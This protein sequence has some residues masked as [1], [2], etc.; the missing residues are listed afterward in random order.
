MKISL[1]SVLLCILISCNTSVKNEPSLF[2]AQDFETKIAEKQVSLYTLHS[3]NGLSMQ[4]TN[5]GG[6]IVSLWV[7]DRNGNYEDVVFGF[8]SI[9]KYI[10]HQG[11]KYLGPVIG[12][13]ANRIANA[14]FELDG[15][16]YQLP[17]N[18]NNNTLHGGS[19]GFESQVWH[20]DKVANNQIQMSYISADGEEGFPGTVKTEMIYKLSEDNELMIKY[21][22]TTDKPTHINLTN[23]SQF[24]LKGAGNGDI[25]D[26]ILSINASH[27]TP[28]DGGLIPTGEIAS[29]EGT[30]FDF[31]MPMLIGARINEDNDQLNKGKGYDHNWV[32]D[33]TEDNKVELVAIV[34]EPQSGRTMEVLTDQPGVQV[35]TGNFFSGK[36]MGKYNKPL[37]KRGAIALEVQKF[38]N[39]PNQPNFPTTRVNPEEVYTQTCIYKFSVK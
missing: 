19:N 28:V 22:A 29:V 37:L 1:Y 16:K 33:K 32:I 31:R 6:R 2:K 10:N 13:Y 25:L 20:V 35:Y 14:E 11:E 15:I 4:V 21:R 34:Y 8:E 3:G 27:I 38:P 24:N 12:R 39:T 5:Y 18:D 23:H 17:A 9:D 36:V 26:H 30:P 7:P